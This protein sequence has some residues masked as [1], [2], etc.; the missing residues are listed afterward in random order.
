MSRHA[1][2]DEADACGGRQTCKIV[3]RHLAGHD[4]PKLAWRSSVDAVAGSAQ[5]LPSLQAQWFSRLRAR[6]DDG[7]SARRPRPP[8]RTRASPAACQRRPDLPRRPRRRSPD[9]KHTK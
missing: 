7:H 9:A 4:R 5:A 1:R 6:A 8:S 2:R 3:M